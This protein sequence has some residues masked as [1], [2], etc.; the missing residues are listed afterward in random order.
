MND[1]NNINSNNKICQNILTQMTNVKIITTLKI[2][3]IK[4]IIKILYLLTK[5]KK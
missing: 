1:C 4:I 2:M 3:K 5:E